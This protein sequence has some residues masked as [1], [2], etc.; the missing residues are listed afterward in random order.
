VEREL[1]GDVRVARVRGCDDDRSR[2]PFSFNGQREQLLAHPRRQRRFE[3]WNTFQ[4]LAQ[5]RPREELSLETR[6]GVGTISEQRI[7]QRDSRLG[8]LEQR[9]VDVFLQ[10]QPA[11]NQ[12]TRESHGHG[13]TM[14]ARAPRDVEPRAR[15]VFELKD[16]FRLSQE[17][18]LVAR[19]AFD[20]GGVG[21]DALDLHPQLPDLV[22][23]PRNLFAYAGA[24]PLQG[25]EA[26]Q[27]PRRQSQ[28]RHRH[29]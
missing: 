6:S 12:A 21:F 1:G 18:E 17:A 2:V 5:R 28:R 25:V 16:Y 9:I 15:S 3:L 23:Q 10:S 24:L 13:R 20:G 29:G 8:V 11:P 19:D 22:R 26:R 14:V 27:A 7:E 4:R